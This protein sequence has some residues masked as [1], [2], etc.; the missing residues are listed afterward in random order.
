[1]RPG[2]SMCRWLKGRCTPCPRRSGALAR[3]ASCSAALAAVTAGSSGRPLDS[4]AAMAEARVQPAGRVGT[5]CF[6]T[7]IPDTCAQVLHTSMS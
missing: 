3:S 5:G 6:K 4:S 1:M 2:G 7:Q